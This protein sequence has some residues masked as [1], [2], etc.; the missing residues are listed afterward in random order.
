MRHYQN[1]QYIF[2]QI[3]AIT[4][5]AYKTHVVSDCYYIGG[6]V[7]ECAL[8]YFVM[9]KKHMNKNYGLDEL[10]AAGL[11]THSLFNLV[12]LASEDSNGLAMDWKKMCTLTKQWSE[13]VRYENSF[14]TNQLSDVTDKFKKDMEEV[15][16][17]V[18]YS[19]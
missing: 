4:G 6:Y 7:M 14:T 2:K 16:K 10:E 12:T 1:C 19:Y 15:Y 18:F 11:K 17:T 3:S 9:S 8:K 13:K 5:G